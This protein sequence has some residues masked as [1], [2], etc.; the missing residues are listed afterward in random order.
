MTLMANRKSLLISL[1]ARAWCFASPRRSRASLN[2][3]RAGGGGAPDQ[4]KADEDAKRKKREEDFGKLVKAP[5]PELRNA[6]PCPFVKVLY[7]AARY[8]RVQG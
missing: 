7:D 5:L 1:D 3:A 2:L 6:G 4:Q 8:H